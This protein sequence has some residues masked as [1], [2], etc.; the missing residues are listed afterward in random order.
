MLEHREVL[1]QTTLPK[2]LA[3]SRLVVFFYWSLCEAKDMCQLSGWRQISCL[4][5]PVCHGPRNCAYSHNASHSQCKFKGFADPAEQ[6]V[7]S[8]GTAKLII[9]IQS[10]EKAEGWGWP[11]CSPP[12]TVNKGGEWEAKGWEVFRSNVFFD[13]R[14]RRAGE[15]QKTF[16]F[17][18][19]RQFVAPGEGRAAG[20]RGGG[21]TLKLSCVS[22]NIDE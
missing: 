3:V 22:S 14:N 8:L 16:C 19:S 6:P 1:S 11:N 18:S 2:A 17:C 12:E 4:Y 15:E 13:A 9:S 10:K 5:S 7:C 21:S 20:G